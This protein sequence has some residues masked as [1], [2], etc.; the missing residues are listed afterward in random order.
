MIGSEREKKID[1]YRSQRKAD[2]GKMITRATAINEL[3]DKALT[4]IE[5]PRPLHERLLAIE[6]RLDEIE[7]NEPHLVKP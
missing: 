4:G 5:P 6:Q 1:T 3:L 2:S 7:N